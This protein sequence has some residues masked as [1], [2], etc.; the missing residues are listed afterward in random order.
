[1]KDSVG[2]VNVFKSVYVKRLAD[3]MIQLIY[4]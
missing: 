2:N 3:N 1:V 4:R